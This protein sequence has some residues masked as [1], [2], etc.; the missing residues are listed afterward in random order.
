MAIIDFFDRG[1][2]I[3]PSG[4]AYIQDEQRYSFDQVGALSCRIAHALLATGLPK[5]SKGAVWAGNDVTA[6]ACTLGLWRA[7]MCWIPVGARNADDENQYLLDAFDCEILFFQ[8]QFA[9]VVAALQPR[10]PK[11][12][13][14]IC[15]DPAAGAQP[16]AATEVPGAVS[17]A[18]WITGQPDTRP[19]VHY[20]PDDVI[21]LSATGGT[22]GKPK[23]VMN[24]HR[25]TQ[26]FCAH[27]MMTC[28][29]GSGEHPV[30]LAA[31]P[32]TH[33]AGL[34]SLP[35]T[36]RGGT[37]V[38]LGAP[39]PAY[40]LRAIA[41]HR[42]TELFLPPTVIY[43]L[44]ERADEVRQYDLSSL[45]YLMYGAAPMSVEKLRQAIALFGPVLT[46][47]Y[48]Q[49]ECPASIA[50]LP[51]DEH[52][53]DGQLAGDERLSSVGRPNPLVTVEIMDEANAILP[54]G[55]TGEICVRGDLLMKGY[56]QAPE[57][58]AATI[59]DGWLH[60]GDIGHIDADG[61][62]HITD[63]KKDMIISGGFNV[64]PSEAEQVIWS[65]PAVRDCAVIGVP[66]SQWGEAVKAVV[67]LNAGQHVD[68][69][70]LIALC[71]HKLGSVKSP[72]TIDFVASLPRSPVGKVLKKELRQQY[73]A[74]TD[75]KI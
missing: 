19:A 39:D 24:T 31:A 5:E 47:G 59:V 73:W 8:A 45:R 9:P 70:E 68:A 33:T 40:L 37:V 1:W 7:N 29:Y 74:G 48:G 58:T 61:Y 27:F 32:M 34:L 3:N 46:G 54:Q 44:L 41:G 53:I 60:T 10:L 62:L 22:T 38:V 11:V 26:T 15:I 42:V 66:D 36:A 57:Q 21:M 4:T 65:H 56:Y 2:R 49:T 13:H 67:E 18:D 28:T 51:P 17:L 69:A 12:R 52:F 25:S 71:K 14:W 75:R 6:W 55:R 20:D 64:Y 23:G 16:S 63:R 35:C 30:N 43:R 50:Y 72:K